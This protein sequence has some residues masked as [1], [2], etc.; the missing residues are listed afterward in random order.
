MI[1][2]KFKNIFLSKALYAR[3]FDRQGQFIEAASR[4]Y[5]ISIKQGLLPSEKKQILQNAL[6]CTLLAPPGF[7]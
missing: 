4:Y 1:N 5:E 6:I 3:V 7:F 2:L